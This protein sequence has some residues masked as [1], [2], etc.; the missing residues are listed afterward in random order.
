MWTT[1]IYISFSTLWREI[2][3]M[4]YFIVRKEMQRKLLRK[5]EASNHPIFLF[6]EAPNHN[7]SN[8]LHL[9]NKIDVCLNL[10]LRF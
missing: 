2:D 10:F 1:D 8:L 4:I 5:N 6:L 3:S 7:Y 9:V